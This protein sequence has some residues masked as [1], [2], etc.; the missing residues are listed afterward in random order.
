MTD[1]SDFHPLTHSE[2]AK[3]KLIEWVIDN[4]IQARMYNMHSLGN[5]LLKTLE[6][7][8]F[9]AAIK[10]AN[11]ANKNERPPLRLIHST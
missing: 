8:L 7:A 2:P 11:T 3:E 4:A 1:K 9:Y 5:S 10:S 6:D